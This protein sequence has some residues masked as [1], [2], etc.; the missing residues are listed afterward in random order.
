MDSDGVFLPEAPDDAEESTVSDHE[1]EDHESDSDEEDPPRKFSF[2]ELD[3]K[4][5][6]AIAQ[7]GAVFPKLNF[8]SPR[9]AAWML[10]ASSP[11]KCISPSDVY[12]LLKSSD[13]V[14]H[15]IDPELVFDG[16]DDTAVEHDQYELEL[17]L[18]K[19]YPVDRSREVRCFVRRE[20]L[21]GL[22]QRDPNYYEF[23][24]EL[25]TQNKV[26][27]AIQSFWEGKI[28]GKWEA[29]DGNYIFDFLLARDLSKGHVL[30]FNP[31]ASKTDSLLFTYDELFDILTSSTSTTNFTPPLKVIDSRMHPATSRNAPMHQHNMVPLEALTLSNGRSMQDFADVLADEIRKSTVDDQ[32][33][34][35]GET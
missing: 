6:D 20:T 24:N 2:P 12:L 4:I 32:D 5:R 25:E 30:D 22:C 27:E 15:D 29:T 9:D 33:N 10:P 8:S 31:Y 13:F 26:V 34:D 1:D 14:Q 17:V 28:K 16:I 7:Y 35:S 3:V 11:L 18:R 23:W 21:I 19:W